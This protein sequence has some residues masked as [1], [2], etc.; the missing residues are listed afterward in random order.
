MDEM[1]Q[2]KENITVIPCFQPALSKD[3]KQSLH[4]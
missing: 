2:E 3:P 1:L 4:C